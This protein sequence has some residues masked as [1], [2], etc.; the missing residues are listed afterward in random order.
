MR[1]VA[2]ILAVSFVCLRARADDEQRMAEDLFNQGLAAM[3]ASPPDYPRACRLFEGSYKIDPSKQGTLLNLA[4]CHEQIGKVA[5]AWSEYRKVEGMA[6]ATNRTDRVKLAREHWQALEPR[7]SYLKIVILPSVWL[8]SMTVAVDGVAVPAAVIDADAGPKASRVVSLAVDPGTHQIVAR[9]PGKRDF[10]TRAVVD[11]AKQTV[12]VQILALVDAPPGERTTSSGPG[13]G[14][15]EGIAFDQ[16]ERVASTRA[17]RTAGLVVGGVGVITLVT[18]GVFGV[19]A[20]GQA[21]NAAECS[22]AAGCSGARYQ[23]AESAHTRANTFA[24]VANVLVPL[25]LV[26]GGVGAA[27]FF[28]AKGGGKDDSKHARTRLSPVLGPGALG[29]SAGGAF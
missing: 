22:N 15:K 18:G 25:G 5:T 9:A 4:G 3:A 19:L 23:D 20:V 26:F 6:A 16:A 28:T 1:R 24:N 13:G 27:L 12:S 14:G 29:L 8:P 17:Q 11:D 7:L 10:V 21:A 2:V